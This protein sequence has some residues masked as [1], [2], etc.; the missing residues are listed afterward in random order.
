MPSHLIVLK[1]FLNFAKG[2]VISNAD[3]VREILGS[4]HRRSVL[5]I[6]PAVQAGG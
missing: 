3:Q 5:K 4:D 1:P 6:G 2:D